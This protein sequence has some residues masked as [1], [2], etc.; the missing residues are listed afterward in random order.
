MLW[1][2]VRFQI[3][4]AD[5]SRRGTDGLA[6]NGTFVRFGIFASRRID[7]VNIN[8]GH[9]LVKDLSFRFYQSARLAV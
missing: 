5:V 9:R 6:V 7:S 4:G 8:D 1:I 3:D 2:D